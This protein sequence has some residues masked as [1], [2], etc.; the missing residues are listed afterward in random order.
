[1]FIS[2]HIEGIFISTGAE[3]K[4]YT[5]RQMVS[6]YLLIDGV[7]YPKCQAEYIK[8]LSTDLSKAQDLTREYSDR[9]G[10][11]ILDL[12]VT[13]ELHEIERL[14]AGDRKAVRELEEAHKQ[15][16]LED[17]ARQQHEAIILSMVDVDL[18]AGFVSGKHEMDERSTQEL[19]DCDPSYAHYLFDNIPTLAQTDGLYQS[20]IQ[21]QIEQ[22]RTNGMITLPSVRESFHVGE[23]GEKLQNVVVTCDRVSGY[24][25]DYGWTHRYTVRDEKGCIYLIDYTGCKW[26]M[27]ATH[28]YIIT[29]KVKAHDQYKGVLQTKM[30]RCSVVDFSNMEELGTSD[31]QIETRANGQSKMERARKIYT[32]SIALFDRQGILSLFMGEL[33][34]TKS[35]AAT[36]YQKLKKEFA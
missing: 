23:V 19:I 1:M 28:K 2:E 25:T 10:H 29:G 36:Y 24:A 13:K 14:A 22:L 33:E 6:G 16:R 35:G 31:N 12:S 30:T 8:N 9:S 15:D 3:T 34:M 11:K 20:R 18:S 32:D 5:L 4:M 26:K 21:Y 27:E 17:Q 7:R